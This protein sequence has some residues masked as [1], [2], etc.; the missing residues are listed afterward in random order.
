[1]RWQLVLKDNGHDSVYC[2]E[3]KGE[4]ETRKGN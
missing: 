1:M 3:G 4:E 2:V